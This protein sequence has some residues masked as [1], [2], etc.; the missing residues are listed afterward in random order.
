VRGRW[1]SPAGDGPLALAVAAALS[2]LA[3]TTKSGGGLAVDSADV[4]SQIVLVLAAGVAG[5]GAVLLPGA[6]GRR[7][8][9]ALIAFAALAALS[10]ASIA[11]S[12]EPAI[13]W[14]EADRTLSYFAAFVLGVLL[15]RGAR[16][17]GPALAAGVA[18]YTAVVCGWALLARVFPAALDASDA[19]GRLGVPFGYYNATG[20]VAAMGLPVWLWLGTRDRRPAPGAGLPAAHEL[21]RADTAAAVASVP[22]VAVLVATLL[23]SY[24]RGAL[25]AAI[26]GVLLWFTVA[27]R[28][29]SGTLVL[30][31]GAV[32]GLATGLWATA[33]TAISHDYVALPLRVAAGH[34]FGV[35]ILVALVLLTASGIALVR[36]RHRVHVGARGRRWIATSLRVCLALVPILVVVGLAASSRG[37]T[38]EVSHLWSSLTNPQAKVPDAPGRLGELGSSRPLYWGDGFKVGG[39]SPVAGVGAGAF[40]VAVR[41]DASDRVNHAHS[42]VVQTFADLGVVG[43]LVSAALLL[44]CLWGWRDA[45][46]AARRGSDSE[47]VATLAALLAVAVI[48]GIHSAIDWTWF[49]PGCTVPAVVCAGYVVAWRRGEPVAGWRAG[50]GEPGAGRR[51]GSGEP[52]LS[53]STPVTRLAQAATEPLRAG[54]ALALLAVALLAAWFVWQPLRSVDAQSAAEDALL[55]GAAGQ[56]LTDART[57]ARA[58]PVDARPHELLA[59]IL[60]ALRRPAAARTELVKAT[61]LQPSNPDTWYALGE[62]DAAHRLPGADAELQRAHALDPYGSAG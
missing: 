44:A 57:A 19:L 34:R 26:V 61:Q 16:S 20:L 36:L 7:A 29:L 21:P 32:G 22:V 10:Y 58:M 39:H 24:G 12:V 48:F 9:V 30:V 46:G 8:R 28:R 47:A 6:L 60:Q 49:V 50:S 35:V 51:P 33:Q 41:R 42:Y 14:Y 13:S 62:F 18:L 45:L 4:W 40:A 37:F 23:L 53:R 11:W 43:L 3:F 2:V 59:S 52:A 17:R 31:P 27:P 15:A 55:R 25:A 54:G 1:P 5:I 38:G 56:A